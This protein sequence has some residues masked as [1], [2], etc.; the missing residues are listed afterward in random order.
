[1]KNIDW[2][3]VIACVISS[4]ITVQS[5]MKFNIKKLNMIFQ[6]FEHDII[7]TCTTEVA[8]YIKKSNYTDI[9]K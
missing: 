5:I 3:T 7:D 9:N 2:V 6:D 4:A 1:M 8:N